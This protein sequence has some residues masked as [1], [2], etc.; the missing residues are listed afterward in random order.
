M[1]QNPLFRK[2]ALDKLASPERLDVLMRVTSPVGWLALLT[3]GLV[4]SG[5]VVWSIYGS[6]PETVEGAGLLTREGGR[7]EARADLGGK[8]DMLSVKV[9]DIVKKDQTIGQVAAIRQ[10]QQVENLEQL[11]ENAR[12][13]A[14]DRIESFQHDIDDLRSKVQKDKHDYEIKFAEYKKGNYTK[15]EIDVV[16][17]RIM[18]NE[19]QIEKRQN[20]IKEE[21]AKV[22]YA[23]KRWKSEKVVTAKIQEIKAPAAG[24]II[25]VVK[26]LGDTVDP[27]DKIATIE[28]MEGEIEATFVVSDKVGKAIKEG[29]DAR[30]FLS[31]LKREKDGFMRATVTKRDEFILTQALATNLFGKEKM[32]KLLGE[33]NKFA[34]HA[35]LLRDE[36]TPSGYKWSSQRG[37]DIKIEGNE[38]IEVTVIVQQVPPYQL[39]IPKVKSALGL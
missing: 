6:I 28:S 18:M 35:E 1:E 31:H 9:D 38:P 8:L 20:Q 11:Y 10:S 13:T 22:D 17:D 23:Y 36:T 29:L 2:A 30:I 24:K 4:V 16:Q 12:T 15:N 39:V 27:G 3:M 26:S 21:N 14:N 7:A 19:S 25:E 33:E 32:Q 37:P 5:V 34:V